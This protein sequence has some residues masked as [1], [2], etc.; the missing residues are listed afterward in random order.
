M[1]KR[2]EQGVSRGSLGAFIWQRGAMSLGLSL[3]SCHRAKV[4]VEVEEKEGE[5]YW[6]AGY[7][8]ALMEDLHV[9]W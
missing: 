9:D 7:D 2:D 8:S 5:D 1:C 4:E 3:C 6:L